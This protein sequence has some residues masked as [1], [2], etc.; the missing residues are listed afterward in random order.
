LSLDAATRR[1]YARQVL[2]GEVGEAGQKRLLD[3][4][5]AAG[6]ASDTSAFAVAADYLRR[7]GSSE[8]AEGRLVALPDGAAVLRFAGGSALVEP[9]A[10]IIGAFCAVEHMKATL[11]ISEAR[12]FPAE[13]RL[14]TKS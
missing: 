11:G 3:A 5:F 6:A 2:L 8:A 7:A 9:A 4:E 14:S 1:R 13:L 12:P 10:A